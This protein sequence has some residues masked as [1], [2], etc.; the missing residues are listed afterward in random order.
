MY[1]GVKRIVKGAKGA[2]TEKG[3]RLGCLADRYAGR[4]S[5]TY[6]FRMFD[7]TQDV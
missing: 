1:K 5:K 7:C 2:Y 4:T 6:T 3:Q